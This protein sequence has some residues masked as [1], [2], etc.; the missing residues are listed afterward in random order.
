[1]EVIGKVVKHVVASH[2]VVIQRKATD[3]LRRDVGLGN[4]RLALR[5]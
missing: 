2:E 5:S 1:V 3:F 4:E